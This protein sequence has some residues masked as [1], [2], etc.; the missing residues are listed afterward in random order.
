MTI[1]ILLNSDGYFLFCFEGCLLFMLSAILRKERDKPGNDDVDE[2]EENIHDKDD[3]D[4]DDDGDDDADNDEDGNDD[5]TST[6][7]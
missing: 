3:G 2:E 6:S 5:A 4:E 1:L 7:V